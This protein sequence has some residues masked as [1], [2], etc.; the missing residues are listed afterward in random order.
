LGNYV[1]RKCLNSQY[2]NLSGDGPHIPHFVFY[3]HPFNQSAILLLRKKAPF[4]KRGNLLTLFILIAM[5]IGVIVGYIIHASATP[6][7]IKA[8]SANIKLLTTIFM[9]LVQMIIAPWYSARW[10]WGLRSWAT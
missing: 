8:F 9:R 2:I 4:M 10:W 3:F 1:G 7:T 5:V 6:E